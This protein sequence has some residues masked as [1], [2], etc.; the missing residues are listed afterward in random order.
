MK[1]TGTCVASGMTGNFML[2]FHRSSPIDDSASGGIVA[3]RS[4]A[5][6]VRSIIFNGS[7]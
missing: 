5:R 4:G 1:R 2:D 6:I 7:A 3:M